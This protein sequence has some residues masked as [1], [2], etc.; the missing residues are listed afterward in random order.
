MWTD[1]RTDRQTHDE[2]KV[3]FGIALHLAKNAF[4]QSEGRTWG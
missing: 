1:S 3:A 2:T 4:L